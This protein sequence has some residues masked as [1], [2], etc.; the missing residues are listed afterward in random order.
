V[1]A[2]SLFKLATEHQLLAEVWAGRDAHGA[3]TAFGKALARMRDRVVA[4][5]RASRVGEDS[6]T[7]VISYRLELVVKSQ[8]PAPVAGVA[9]D[10]GGF[11]DD[12]K[13]DA[14]NGASTP[15]H[16]ALETPA[17]NG[18][19]TLHEEK[20]E[21]PKT[22]AIPRNPRRDPWD[23]FLDEAGDGVG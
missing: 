8:T 21:S 12:K 17:T 5:F 23:P 2:D 11:S 22:P 18:A 15:G 19:A 20:F 7:K 4:S 3:R 14:E 6:H 16:M 1:T 13:C 10:C 9:G